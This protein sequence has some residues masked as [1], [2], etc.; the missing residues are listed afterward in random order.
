MSEFETGL[1]SIRQVQGLIKV[2]N[3][4]ELRLT[5]S[6]VISGK[7]RWQD[8]NCLCLITASQQTIIIWRHAI[9]YLRPL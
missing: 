6:D 1:P 9:A 5:T 2:G 3:E 8:T 7:L 4:V